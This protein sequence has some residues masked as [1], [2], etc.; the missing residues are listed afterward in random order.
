LMKEIALFENKIK[1]YN[2]E[3]VNMETKR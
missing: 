3:V 1:A 2:K